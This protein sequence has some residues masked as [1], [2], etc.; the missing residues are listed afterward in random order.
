MEDYLLCFDDDQLVGVLGLWDTTSFKQTVIHSY[1]IWL[2]LIRPIYNFVASRMATFPQ[3]PKEGGK[4]NYIS[5]HSLV[6][7]D[8]NPEVFKALLSFLTLDLSTTFMVTLD[9]RDPLYPTMLKIHPTR[10][11]EGHY[12]LI[13]RSKE[14]TKSEK[15]IPVDGPI[16]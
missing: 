1:N 11:K 3:L 2:R 6:I 5:I 16:I 9:K 12:F 8:R 14:I 13:T 4:L 10:R 7:S 15:W